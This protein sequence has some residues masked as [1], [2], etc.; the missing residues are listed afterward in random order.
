M[1]TIRSYSKYR[2]EKEFGNIGI[3]S[4]V[5]GLEV[6]NPNELGKRSSSIKICRVMFIQDLLA[7]H[8]VLAWLFISKGV[9]RIVSSW[10]K[11]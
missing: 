3:S 4:T 2:R 7:H 5:S 10:F 8:R 6:R 11:L 9:R 1:T